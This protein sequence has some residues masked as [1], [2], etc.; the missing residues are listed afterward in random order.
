MLLARVVSVCTLVKMATDFSSAN[1]KALDHFQD[2]RVQL[3][4]SEKKEKLATKVY[5]A[6]GGF[7]ITG[8]QVAV[9]EIGMLYRLLMSSCG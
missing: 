5:G 1:R 7:L 9:K 6:I 3:G 8:I 4:M 2:T